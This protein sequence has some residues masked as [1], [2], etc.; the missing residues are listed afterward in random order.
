MNVGLPGLGIFEP[1]EFI[2]RLLEGPLEFRGEGSHELH[3]IGL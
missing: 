3:L 2:A 1:D